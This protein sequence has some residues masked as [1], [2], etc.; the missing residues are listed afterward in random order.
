MQ[1]QNSR[2]FVRQ[3]YGRTLPVEALLLAF[4][5]HLAA[6]ARP[7]IVAAWRA[8]TST[9]AEMRPFQSVQKQCYTSLTAFLANAPL[10]RCCTSQP[11]TACRHCGTIRVFLPDIARAPANAL[12][13]PPHSKR[14]P[15]QGSNACLTSST[16][17][18]SGRRQEQQQ[19]TITLPFA[20]DRELQKHSRHYSGRHDARRARG[21]RCP[22]NSHPATSSWC[23]AAAPSTQASSARMFSNFSSVHAAVQ[24][25]LDRILHQQISPFP[26][27]QTGVLRSTASQACLGGWNQPF[28]E[29]W[30]PGAAWPAYFAPPTFARWRKMPEG[31]L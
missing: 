11:A 20:L 16:S 31:A 26:A 14:R 21:G 4:P 28:D 2:S 9:I 25:T 17:S 29:I 10:R 13:A 27:S 3:H 15:D 22:Q 5:K 8:G 6:R 18:T 24:W 19:T 1:Q 12:F 7:S 30:K 23:N